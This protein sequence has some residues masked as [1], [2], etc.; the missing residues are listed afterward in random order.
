MSEHPLVSIVTPS[1]NQARFL[2]ETIR[3]VLDQDYPAIEYIIVDGGS[4]DGSVEIIRRFVARLAWWVS[5]K[6]KGQ[7]DALNKGFER[8]S[9]EIF[10]RHADELRV[11]ATHLEHGFQFDEP[12]TLFAY[13]FIGGVDNTRNYDV[14]ADG[15]RILAVSI[16]EILIPRQIEV[17]TDWTAQLPALAP[18]ER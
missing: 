13:P 14:T 18:A 3:S 15:S 8:G 9:G 16:P 7:S 11:V 5:E 6:D 1:F 2:A 12:R 10:F 17:V 4:T